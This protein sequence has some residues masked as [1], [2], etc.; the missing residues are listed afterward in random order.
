MA[1]SQEP[2]AKELV[3]E[4][5]RKGLSNHDI[6]QE[7]R[8]DPK[9]VWKILNDKTSGEHYRETLTELARDGHATTRPARRRAKDGHIVPVRAKTGSET[10]TVIPEDTVGRYVDQPK[11]GSFHTQTTYFQEGGRQHEIKMPKT[12]TAIGRSRAQ[13][14]LM[15]KVQKAA[16]GQ[17]KND[18]RVKFSLTFSNGRV[19][20]V[21][22]KSGY[23]ASDVLFN[24]R[25]HGG[26]AVGWLSTQALDRYD[27]LDLDDVTVTGV[28]LTVYDAP[29]LAREANPYKQSNSSKPDV[30]KNRILNTGKKR[31]PFNPKRDLL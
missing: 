30:A 9:M 31:R 14:D 24:V 20:E 4:L 25:K 21:G 3:I 19:M 17:K 7:I 23:F 22:S 6:A 10:K 29:G 13:A 27:N 28:T 1:E 5:K 15:D 12:K 18:K 11:K 16:K 8:R 2:T 26:D